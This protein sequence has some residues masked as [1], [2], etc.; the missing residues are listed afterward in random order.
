MKW[1]ILGLYL[2]AVGALVF[3]AYRRGRK[4]QCKAEEEF[5]KIGRHNPKVH[6]VYR[7]A[8]RRGA[9]EDEAWAAARAYE[10][11]YTGKL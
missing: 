10:Q 8:I 11:H 7:L 3:Y 6:R 4:A 1:Y 9:T 5:R 2:C